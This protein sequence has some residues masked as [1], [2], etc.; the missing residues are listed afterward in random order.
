[1][2]QRAPPRYRRQFLRLKAAIIRDRYRGNDEDEDD[3]PEPPRHNHPQA[4]RGLSS[5][6]RAQITQEAFSAGGD[7]PSRESSASTTPIIIRAPTTQ[8]AFSTR[9]N[10][11]SRGSSASS[12]PIVIRPNVPIAPNPLS[13]TTTRPS[14]TVNKGGRLPLN[15]PILEMTFM[16]YVP[17]DQDPN[18]WQ[19]QDISMLG[20]VGA[21]LKNEFLAGCFKDDE[22]KKRYARMSDPTTADVIIRTNCCV[23]NLV[24]NKGSRGNNKNGLFRV[25]H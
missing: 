17:R 2:V 13:T 10:I 24:L 5:N 18:T 14:T 22:S 11:S 6:T 12:T 16:V 8:E 21:N 4:P 19:Y 7:I 20:G 15:R 1:M 9:G 23:L 25:C 3:T